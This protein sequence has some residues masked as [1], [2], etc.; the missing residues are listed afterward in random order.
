MDRRVIPVLVVAIT[1][2]LAGLVFIQSIWVRNTMELKDA[3]FRE[4]ID[5]ALIAVSD[6][7]ERMEA[8]DDI[9]QHRQGRWM[10]ERIDSLERLNYSGSPEDSGTEQ[11]I[12]QEA[13]DIMHL[14]DGHLPP[15]PPHKPDA[16]HAALGRDELLNDVFEG[17]LNARPFHAMSERIDGRTLDSLINDELSRRGINE[18]HE[19]G[20]FPSAGAPVI[21]SLAEPADSGLV[22]ASPHRTR[23]F[24]NDVGGEPHWLH[25][26]VPGQQRLVLRSMWPMLLA[27]AV[28]VLLI[29]SVFLFT[30]RTI[31]RQKRL[32]DIRTDLV[33][34]LTHE[35]KTPIS[36]I[37]LA[38]EALNDPGL[39]KGPEQMKVFTT[40]IRDENKRLGMLVESVLQSAVVDSG[41]MRLR[42]A[43]VDLH[44]VLADV[45]RNSAIQAQ[46]RGGTL[47][48]EPAAELAHVRGDRI[49]LTNVFYNLVDNAVK[50][51]E[52]EPE[53][54]V[55]TQ[56]DATGITVTVRDNGIGIPRAE[57]KKIFERLYR[58][59]TGNLHNVKG[60]G[61]GL[62]YVKAVVERHGGSIRVES[63]P[64]VGSTFSI[65]LPF[66][67]G[68]PDQ[69]TAV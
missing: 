49:H 67:H 37:A 66:E 43:D 17:I 20:V 48:L 60:F 62:S 51:C 28:F 6:R 9:R 22:R 2:A 64:G 39:P 15:P 53:V 50:Y 13:Q 11:A 3:Q 32:S 52:R 26:Y 27:S 33:N 31:L 30:V 34:N 36:T 21:M 25:L 45:V 57:Q 29:G 41:K 68:E 46:N 16:A 56:S 7:L 54:R 38:C 47:T 44:A 55:H 5:N 63:E 4:S 24:R 58:V 61:L 35:L 8:V 1:V 14:Q 42:W 69:A 18:P 59:P 10:L 40:M 12:L 23:L 65:T 19:Y